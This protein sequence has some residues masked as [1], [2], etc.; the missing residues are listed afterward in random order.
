MSWP[1]GTDLTQYS[2]AALPVA[3]Q[4]GPVT[5][6]F[7]GWAIEV[8]QN[9]PSAVRGDPEG[10]APYDGAQP[11]AD[12]IIVG[13]PT[14]RGQVAVRPRTPQQ[15]ARVTDAATGGGG[16]GGLFG[17]LFG[18]SAGGG[19]GLS[20]DGGLFG[21]SSGSSGGLFG[22]GIPPLLLLLLLSGGGGG[23]GGIQQLLLLSALLGSGDGSGGGLLGF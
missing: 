4:T 21:S 3:G 9:G 14:P 20:G 11:V 13:G 17:G 22:G 2:P 5:V 15:V 16:G 23:G 18:A 10:V 1:I 7:Q 6:D 12:G 8:G 19:L